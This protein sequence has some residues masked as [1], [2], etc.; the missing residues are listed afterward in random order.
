MEALDD[1]KGSDVTKR[2]AN[3]QTAY[4]LRRWMLEQEELDSI[5]K[6]R[7]DAHIAQIEEELRSLAV[8]KTRPME[9]A[10]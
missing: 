5:R 6:Q 9:L 8:S 3:L 2:I 4:N 7:I 10:A 1:M